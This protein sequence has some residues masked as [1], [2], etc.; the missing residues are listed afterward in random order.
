[1]EKLEAKMDD[2][3]ASFNALNITLAERCGR[4]NERLCRA[5]KDIDRAFVK[6][7]GV[8]GWV[9]A[10]ASAIGALLTLFYF[11]LSAKGIK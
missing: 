8:W 3:Q 9:V 4:E 1:M 2:L 5:E 7:R 10:G 6:L 11:L